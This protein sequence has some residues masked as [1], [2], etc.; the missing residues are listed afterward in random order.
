MDRNL[1]SKVYMNHKVGSKGNRSDST[2]RD[3]ITQAYYIIWCHIKSTFF[4]LPR[5][6]SSGRLAESNFSRSL[7]VFQYL[8]LGDGSVLEVECQIVSWLPCFLVVFFF[9]TSWWLGGNR[10]RPVSSLPLRCP[11]HTNSLPIHLLVDL[12]LTSHEVEKRGNAGDR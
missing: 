8:S 4:L 6:C 2:N 9:L 12:N 3:S 7:L 11:T 1:C 10:G 5:P